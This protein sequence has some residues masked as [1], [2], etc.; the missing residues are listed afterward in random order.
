MAGIFIVRNISAW[1]GRLLGGVI[2]TA[3]GVPAATAEETWTLSGDLRGGYFA[4]ESKARNGTVTEVDALRGRLRLAAERDIGAD[5]HFRARLAGRYGQHQTGHGF[6]LH[7]YASTSTGMALGE[8]TLDEFYLDY[9]DESRPWSLR[10]GRFQN[11]FALEGVASKGL[12]RNDSPNIDV[13]WT[14]GIHYRHRIQPG[15]RAHLVLQHNHRNGPGAAVRAPLDFSDNGSRV[16]VFSGLEATES[17]GPIVQRMIGVTWM[18]EALASDGT[19]FSRR[20]DYIT[21]VGRMAASWT[22]TDDGLRLVP[23]FEIGYAPN[24]PRATVTGSGDAGDA[25]GL[26]WQAAVSFYDIAPGHHLGLVYARIDAGWL[27]SGDFRGNDELSEVRYQWRFSPQ[28][29]FEARYRLREEIDVPAAA[30]GRREDRD[31]YLRISGR[32]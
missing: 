29:S 31:F 10:V 4:S 18:P 1:A 3:I 27:L 28:W 22:L 32:F 5:F 2:A 15:W 16:A 19:A 11:R 23:G 14:D 13:T 25:G 26:A 30:P 7:G 12:D 24:R 21:L 17:L 6:H 9:A 8:T 20:E